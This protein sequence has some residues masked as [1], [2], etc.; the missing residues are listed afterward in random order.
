MLL[1]I[2]TFRVWRIRGEVYMGYG[3]LCVCLPVPRRIPTLLHGP[4]CNLAEW[5]GVP[6]SCALL[7]GFAIGARVSLP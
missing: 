6:S 4:G 1:S 7:G 3:R 2:T 5:Y